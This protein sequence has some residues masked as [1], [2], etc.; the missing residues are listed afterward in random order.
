MSK[1]K[2]KYGKGDKCWSKLHKEWKAGTLN[3]GK[4]KKTVPVNKT[5]QYKAIAMD[6]CM[7]EIRYET[8]P[9]LEDEL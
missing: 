7:G 3:I 6:V 2:K 9:L 4:S 5:S 1:S 8:Y